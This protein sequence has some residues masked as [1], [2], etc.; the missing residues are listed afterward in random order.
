MSIK[1]PLH[2]LQA[3]LIILI[4]I[5]LIYIFMKMYFN[6]VFCNFPLFGNGF[7]NF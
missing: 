6:V 1:C 2:V 3:L 4:T 5:Y 7:D